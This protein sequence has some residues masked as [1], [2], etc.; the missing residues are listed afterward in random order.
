MNRVYCDDIIKHKLIKTGQCVLQMAET[1]PKWTKE[2]QI[3]K[4][5]GHLQGIDKWVEKRVKMVEKYCKRVDGTELRYGV[6]ITVTGT[7]VGLTT[8]CPAPPPTRVDEAPGRALAE[9]FRLVGESHLN[10]AR[11]VSGRRLYPDSVGRQQLKQD[12]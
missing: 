1:K 8:P 10:H 11:D 3:R 9:L 5:H 7:T 6:G 4:L 12:R 2:I